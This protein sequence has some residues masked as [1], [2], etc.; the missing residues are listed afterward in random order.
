MTRPRIDRRPRIAEPAPHFHTHERTPAFTDGTADAR[1]TLAELGADRST[2]RALLDRA[3]EER[4]RVPVTSVSYDYWAAHLSV[5]R[6]A[7]G[8]S[9]ERDMERHRRASA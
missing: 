2:L 4:N 7:F 8:I 9:P 3:W 1:A 6:E 5:Y